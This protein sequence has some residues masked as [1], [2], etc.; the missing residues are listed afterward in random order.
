MENVPSASEEIELEAGDALLLPAA[1]VT[2]CAAA[3]AE[4]P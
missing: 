1:T 4:R 2:C 3:S